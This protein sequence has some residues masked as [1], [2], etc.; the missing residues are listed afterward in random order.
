M[1]LF[2]IICNLLKIFKQYQMK[3]LVKLMIITIKQYRIESILPAPLFNNHLTKSV[4]PY[5]TE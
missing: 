5:S 4:Y 3:Y 1:S 2:V